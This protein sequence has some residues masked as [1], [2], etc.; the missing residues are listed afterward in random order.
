MNRIRE[1]LA[2]N[3]DALMN[4]PGKI[5]DVAAGFTIG[6]IVSFT[7]LVGLHTALTILLAYLLNKSIGAGIIGTLVFNPLTAPLIFSASILVGRTILRIEPGAK[8][9]TMDPTL[10]GI[11]QMW[12]AGSGMFYSWMAGGLILGAAAGV[13][14]FFLVRRSMTTY[15]T[16]IY[17]KRKMKKEGRKQSA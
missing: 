5:N 3:Y 11:H 6:V 7:P 1:H 8:P 14:S 9:L 16:R 15:Q 4:T 17:I 2:K 13:V 10:S 12:S